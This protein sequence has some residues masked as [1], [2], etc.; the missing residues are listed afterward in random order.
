MVSKFKLF[1]DGEWIT[2]ENGETYQ[3]V[4]PADPEDVLGEFQ[5][6]NKQD[7]EKAIEAAQFAFEDWSETPAP[8]RA[9]YLIKVAQFLT[10]QQDV[11]A[12]YMTREMGKTLRDSCADVQEAIDLAY[13]AAAEG[14]RLGGY[15][16]PSEKHK[17]FAM[18]LRLP[19][20]VAGLISPWNF[21]LAIPARKLFYAL[22]CGNT[23][24]LKPAS[25]TP[26]CAT[27]LVELLDKAGI[28]KGVVNLVTGP[29]ESVGMTL[30]KDKRVPVVSFTGHKDTGATILQE[31]GVK[32][33]HLELGGKNPVIV[34][35]DADLKLAVDGVL[36]GGYETSGQRCTAAS[37]VIVHEKVKKNFEKMLLE[38]VRR[39]KLG[40]GLDSKT[41][42][43]PLVNEAA[44]K[45]VAK[46]VEIGKTEGA[47][48]L[49]GGSVPSNMKGWFFEP[50]L[51]TDCT[52]F[53]RIAQEEIFGPVVSLLPALDLSDALNIA[54]CVEYGLSSSI[55]TRSI[56]NAI[57]AVNKLQTGLTYINSSTIGSEVQLPFGGAKQSGN[58]R[59][60]GPE[61]VRQFTE[62]KTIYID[63]SGKL[64]K[65]FTD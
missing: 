5:K 64:Q 44:Q 37:R 49:T 4:N 56:K 39:L 8:K 41:D 43:G 36:W 27:K 9:K 60:D 11:L 28:P 29:G 33:V 31:A 12:R 40:N 24:V 53:M 15:T 1:I 10:E 14:K 26:I 22:I 19:I 34:M 63:Y 59:E 17:K 42:V 21:P 52:R 38:K 16:V 25:D 20:G 51:F 2:A 48:L 62:L 61:G 47:K 30:V 45:K 32:R 3:R 58:T 6:G 57:V 65:A 7:T 18:T 55:Y 54:N 23:T 35:D 46:Y 50:T 13:Y